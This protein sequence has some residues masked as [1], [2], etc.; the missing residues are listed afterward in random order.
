MDSLPALAS[1]IV[2]HPDFFAGV[3]VPVFTDYLN[4]QIP[5]EQE[6]QRFFVTLSVCFI[7]GLFFKWTDLAYGSWQSVVTSAAIIFTESQL[8]YKS[9]FQKS[10]LREFYNNR[11]GGNNLLEDALF[12]IEE[13]EKETV[14]TPQLAG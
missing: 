10:Y 7:L 6:L 14:L 13:E 4:K 9:Y 3:A 1:Y 2:A 8:V 11:I 12:R 5:K